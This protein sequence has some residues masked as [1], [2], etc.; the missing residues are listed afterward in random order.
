M[1]RSNRGNCG[2]SYS[3][4]LRNMRLPLFGDLVSKQVY[5]GNRI[6]CRKLSQAL[7]EV[8]GGGTG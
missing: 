4:N 5:D 7:S 2:R 3:N 8:K 6:I 1:S